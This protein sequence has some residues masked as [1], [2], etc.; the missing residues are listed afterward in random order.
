MSN[1]RWDK[2][3]TKNVQLQPCR[4]HLTYL[5]TGVQL[6]VITGGRRPEVAGSSVGIH[7]AVAAAA[8]AAAEVSFHT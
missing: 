6:L 8:A 4:L 2:K 7:P 3:Q 1:L 5:S